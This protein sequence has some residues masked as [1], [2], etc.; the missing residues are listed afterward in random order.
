MHIEYLKI[1]LLFMH[2]DSLILIINKKHCYVMGLYE[3][4]KI[5]YIMMVYYM[6][7]KQ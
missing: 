3:T 5:I 4:S 2:A 1:L 6:N 7:K